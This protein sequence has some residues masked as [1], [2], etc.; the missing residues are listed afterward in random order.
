MQYR[1]F[2]TYPEYAPTPIQNAALSESILST[3]NP[4]WRPE[5]VKASMLMAILEVSLYTSLFLII[6]LRFP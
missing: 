3:G 5:K 6:L 2:M 1:A 4:I